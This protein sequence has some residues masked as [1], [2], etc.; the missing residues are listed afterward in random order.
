MPLYCCS[1]SRLASFFLLVII[2]GCFCAAR[3]LLFLY[4]LGMLLLGH[5]FGIQTLLELLNALAEAAT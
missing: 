4:S 3:L 2:L 5:L 1:K